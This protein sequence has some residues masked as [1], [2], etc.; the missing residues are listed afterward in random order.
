MSTTVYD[1][2]TTIRGIELQKKPVFPTD[3]EPGL[4]YTMTYRTTLDN[5]TVLF[6]DAPLHIGQ[7]MTVTV[8]AE[9]LA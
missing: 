1:V 5:G 6:L 3:G 8:V 9:D 4:T 7:T 2:T